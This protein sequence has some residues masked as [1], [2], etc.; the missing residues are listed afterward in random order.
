MNDLLAGV[1]ENSVWLSIVI[2]F[3]AGILSSISPCNLS[4]IPLLIGY[5]E[6]SEKKEKQL[7]TSNKRLNLS[8]TFI[9]G[10]ATTFV[11]MGLLFSLLGEIL[12]PVREVL[13]YLAVLVTFFMG[14]VLLNFLPFQFHFSFEKFISKLKFKGSLDS[15]LLGFLMG[16][17]TSQC[18]TPV[19]LVILTYV[20]LQGKVLFGGLLLFIFALGRGVPL[21]LLGTFSGM[22]L[23]VNRFKK[24]SYVFQYLMG[25]ILITMSFYL[26]W[27]A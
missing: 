3:I 27:I 20:M 24:Y 10:T 9:L 19:L 18:A 8:I 2:V 13:T 1:L 12:N 7:F 23:S 26:F 11:S 15:Y 17:T 25:A 5:L 6:A 14:L 21:V 4:S 16:F 22:V